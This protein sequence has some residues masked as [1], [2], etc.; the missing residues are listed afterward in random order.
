[1]NVPK[2]LIFLVLVAG[3]GI[4]AADLFHSATWTRQRNGLPKSIPA[5]SYRL[6]GVCVLVLGAVGVVRS[7]LLWETVPQ[8]RLGA[9][10]I[11]RSVGLPYRW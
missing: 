9:R 2:L 8:R 11:T 4:F 5:W 6:A 7:F 1:M 10:L 3:G